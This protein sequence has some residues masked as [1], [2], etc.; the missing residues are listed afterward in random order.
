VN[1]WSRHKHVNHKISAMRCPHGLAEV[2]L[3]SPGAQEHWY[4]GY[5]ILHAQAPVHRIPGAGFEPGTD[6]FILSKHED[7]ARVVGDEE[8]FPVIGSIALRRLRTYKIVRNRTTD[9]TQ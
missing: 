6:A 4:E 5:D 3:F 1:L 8:R 7:I 2:D 9:R